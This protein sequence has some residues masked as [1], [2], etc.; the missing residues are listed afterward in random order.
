[1]SHTTLNTHEHEFEPQYG[2]PER[3]PTG[4]AIVWQGSPVWL[5]L[6]KQVFHV[7]KIALY[8]G[9]ILILRGWYQWGVGAS[10][11]T[12]LASIVMLAPLFGI[13]LGC[14]YL[15]AYYSAKT[16]VYTITSKRVVMRIGIVLSVTYNI[17]FKEIFAAN[18]VKSSSQA[19]SIVLRLKP[20]TRIAYLQLW[21]H[22]RPWM[23]RYPQPMLRNL[24]SAEA[25]AA[26]LADAWAIITNGV[27]TDSRSPEHAS[28]D[29]GKFGRRTKQLQGN[30][31]AVTSGSSL[32]IQ[33]T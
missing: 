24:A 16:T 8:F 14:L 33:S 6:A 15:L 20:G 27:V 5:D 1:M 3:L 28:S 25:V 23:L 9:I 7:H 21:P 30:V 32:G 18:L 12:I 4:E 11:Q 31:P 2:L 10:W 29:P 13:A 17:P 19:S 26:V 22:V